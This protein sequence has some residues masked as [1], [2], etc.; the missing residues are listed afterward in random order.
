M[1]AYYNY[2]GTD[3]NI[4]P[5]LNINLESCTFLGNRA[6]TGTGWGGGVY[7]RDFIALVNDCYFLDNSA[8]SGGGL[9]L[10]LGDMTITGGLISG[11]TS[12]GGDTYEMG[13]GVLFVNTSTVIE[14]CILS[15]NVADGAIR[16]SG[17]AIGFYGG[18]LT[19]LVKNCLI[20]GNSATVSGG[21]ISAYLLAT[22]EIRNSTFNENSA[23]SLGGAIFCDGDS[24]PTIIDS[25]FD[26]CNSHAILEEAT[27]N[28]T[29][30]NSLF[31]NNTDGDYGI[32]DGNTGL[33]TTTAGVDLDVT[34]IEGDPL[35]VAG[36][37]GDYYLSHIA[38]GQPIDSNCI[39]AGS[40]DADA[41]NI[42]MDTFTTRID[43][44]N[45]MNIVDI[46][47]HY[48]DRLL[49]PRYDLTVILVGGHG[50]V[51]V[52][53]PEPIAFDPATDTYT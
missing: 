47:Y 52:N 6:V 37:F 13:G 44:V 7:Y 9:Q 36:P 53:Q 41:P 26:N 50:T 10:T 22:P 31:Y 27:G 5:T 40:G 18:Q 38:T 2:A 20:T 17:G 11:N 24:D 29:V 39:D 21:A 23:G 34:N 48:S 14:N 33:T 43:G 35:F 1:Y 15:D 28:G 30:L 8:R 16:G 49:A 3:P 12:I 46:G 25:I 42:G 51:E 45:D 32:Y 4:T 19:H